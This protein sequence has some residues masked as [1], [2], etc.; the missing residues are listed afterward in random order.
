MLWLCVAAAAG[1]FIYGFTLMGMM[2]LL[3]ILLRVRVSEGEF[4]L[5]SLGAAKW[6]LS[7]ALKSPVSHTFMNIIV[8][9]PFMV[10]F[11]RLMGARVG[12]GV[13]INSKSCADPLLLEIGDGSVIGGHATIIGHTFERGKL[14]LKKVTI[15]QHVVVGLNA[16]ILPGAVIGD[17]AVI[18]A[19]AIVPKDTIVAPGAIYKGIPVASDDVRSS[20]TRPRT[21]L[22][23]PLP[24]R[25]SLYDS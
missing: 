11:L 10:F 1:L 15:G 14:I 25:R 7:M 4:P 17:G 21:P 9:T 23:M 8:L 22:M 24:R 12:R 18:A 6:G 20:F 3:R 2:G 13:H 5:L 19:G 16:V